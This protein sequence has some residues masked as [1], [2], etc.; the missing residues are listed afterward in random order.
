M[1]REPGRSGIDQC[2]CNALRSAARRV[3]NFYDRCLETSGLRVTQYV[4]LA[5]LIERPGLSVN[6]LAEA[7]ELDRT[8]AGKNLRPLERDG[9]VGIVADEADG[10]SKRVEL[11]NSGRAAFEIAMPL[12]QSA[13]A[14]LESKIGIEETSGLRRTLASIDV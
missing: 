5:L 10:R 14:A 8:T 6:E 12:W 13:Q 9:L 4:I 7:L 11:T 3:T 2:N 1:A